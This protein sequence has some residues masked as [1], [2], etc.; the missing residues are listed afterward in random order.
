[1][2]YIHFFFFPSTFFWKEISFVTR[3][4]LSLDDK[5]ASPEIWEATE[6]QKLKQVS[7]LSE[8]RCHSQTGQRIML[9]HDLLTLNVHKII[10]YRIKKNYSEHFIDLIIYAGNMQWQDYFYIFL[11]SAII[12]SIRHTCTLFPGSKNSKTRSAV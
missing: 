7:Y 3:I 1:M 6:F 10:S 11:Y 8:L 9:Y 12:V 2:L 5:M 4:Y